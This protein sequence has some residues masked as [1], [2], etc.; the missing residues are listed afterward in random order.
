[1]GEGIIKYS[2]LDLS[3]G[4]EIINK[5]SDEPIKLV[6]GLKDQSLYFAN[7]KN[8]IIELL[9][10]NERYKPDLIDLRFLET[11]ILGEIFYGGSNAI[12]RNDKLLFSIWI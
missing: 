2:N 11:N 10:G 4:K 9:K 8:E 12:Y 7:S 5:L 3:T 6:N 1:M